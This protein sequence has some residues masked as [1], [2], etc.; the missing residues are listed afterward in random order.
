MNFILIMISLLVST[1]LSVLL[2]KKRNHKWLAMLSALFINTLFLTIVVWVYY[3]FDDETRMFGFGHSGRYVLFF[4]IP[5]ITWINFLI[6]SFVI[7][8]DVRTKNI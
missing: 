2:W 4:S 3:S 8:R 7:N 5:I 6:L 1:S